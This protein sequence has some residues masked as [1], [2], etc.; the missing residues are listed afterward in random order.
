MPPYLCNSSPGCPRGGALVIVARGPLLEQ[1]WELKTSKMWL[2]HILMSCVCSICQENSSTNFS[3]TARDWWPLHW[4]HT[5]YVWKG[6]WPLWEFEPLSCG[7]GYLACRWESSH[8]I[9]HTNSCISTSFGC[10]STNSFNLTMPVMS[11]SSTSASKLRAQTEV[12]QPSRESV[13]V[14]LV[15]SG[16]VRADLMCPCAL[17]TT[18]SMVE[19]ILRKTKGERHFSFEMPQPIFCFL[20]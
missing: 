5:S 6:L 10:P 12:V 11:G 18:P 9:T 17:I 4:W 1:G 15:Q 8:T 19:F 20:C 3:L 16:Q 7:Q 2:S 14:V 13:C